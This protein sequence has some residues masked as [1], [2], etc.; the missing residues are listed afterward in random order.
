ML[1]AKA[2][3]HGAISIV[4]AIPTGR[5][6]VMGISLRT[7]A[8]A[9]AMR[10][11]GIRL[12]SGADSA[13]LIQNTVRLSVPPEM[14]REYEISISIK[15]EIPMGYGLKSSS[16]ISVAAA[17]A[18]AALFDSCPNDL[19]ALQASAD[20]SIKSRVSI[21]GAYDDACG[22][23]YGGFVVTDNAKRRMLRREP[24]DPDLI[25]VIFIPARKQR[26]NPRNLLD[27]AEAFDGA[28]NLANESRY[29]EAMT[30]NGIAA[31]PILGVGCG[32]DRRSAPRRGAGS[33][34][35]RKRPC[36]G[37]RRPSGQCSERQEGI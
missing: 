3:V 21:T 22:C 32:T 15:S 1:K 10:G 33:V 35:V 6:A 2:T 25:A 37:R 20:A 9:Q 23:C 26:R 16:S 12:A 19:M 36:R 24:A 30:A 31:A 4:N 17:L 11:T 34:S 13:R 28:W 18:S 27:R 29:W 7:E 14:L 5:G 8:T